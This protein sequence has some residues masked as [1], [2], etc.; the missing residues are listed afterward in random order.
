MASIKS[1]FSGK[2]FLKINHIDFNN[3]TN[4]KSLFN[5]Q[6]LT[7]FYEYADAPHIYYVLKYFFIPVLVFCILFL[8]SSLL[9]NRYKS[10]QLELKTKNI[11]ARLND[12]LTR[13]IFQET[14]LE[15]IK[16]QIIAFKNTIPFDEKWCRFL[17][18]NKIIG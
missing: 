13:L 14:E 5:N 11:D 6:K 12:F 18:L 3:F 17:V 4:E 8:V 16:K 15:V 10:E 9:L 1:F 2:V 7:K